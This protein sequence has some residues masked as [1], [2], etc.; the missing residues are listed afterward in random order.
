MNEFQCVFCGKS[1]NKYGGKVT[2]LLITTNWE[3]EE[4]QEDQQVFCHLKCLREKCYLK[5]SIYIDEEK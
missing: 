3:T 4:E 5:E 2:S 1:I